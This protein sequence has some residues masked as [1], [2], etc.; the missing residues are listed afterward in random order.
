MRAKKVKTVTLRPQGTDIRT[1]FL[2]RSGS[3]R[4]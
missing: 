1:W 4:R 3:F 2:W